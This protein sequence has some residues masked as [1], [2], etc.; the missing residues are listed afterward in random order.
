MKIKEKCQKLATLKL[1]KF[2]KDDF[3]IEI[4]GDIKAIE[5]NGQHGIELFATAYKNGKQVG[6]GKKGDVEIERFR[7]FNPPVLVDDEN[8]DIIREWAD[9]I[10][11]EVKQRKLKYDTEQALKNSLAHTISIVA[12]DS[13]NIVKGKIGN[14]TSTFYPDA[15]TGNTTVDGYCRME[16][17]A[18]WASARDGAGNNANAT[19]TTF[20][21][22]S[23]KDINGFS[24]Y[25]GILTFDT[26]AIDTDDVISSVILSLY[27]SAVSDTDNDGQDYMNIV[28]S[29]PANN[30]NVVSG[31]FDS[32]GTTKFA[33]DID[34]GDFTTSAYNNFVFNATGILAVEKDGITKLGVR[35][36]HDI[37]DVSI[38][39]DLP[40]NNNMLTVVS[41]DETG[42]D[43][44]PKL[45][46]VHSAVA[47]G[48]S[49]AQII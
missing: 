2:K 19:E 15:G 9:E 30:N 21:A 17:Q 13:K 41:A 38:A 28:A 40:T 1:S 5:I 42:T 10:T 45:V 49:F 23:Y 7:F 34:L 27:V 22:A 16:D 31:D 24:I 44:D 26:S 20:R 8:G 47:V 33:T 46:V 12:K 3:E 35:E 6:F 48:K 37:E 11:K 39:T 43:T 14:T 36:G 25:R 4:V 18:S 32:L 29:A